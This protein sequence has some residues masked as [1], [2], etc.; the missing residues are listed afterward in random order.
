[1]TTQNERSVRTLPLELNKK[2][3][4]VFRVRCDKCSQ[5]F[6]FRIDFHFYLEP[7]WLIKSIPVKNLCER[8]KIISNMKNDIKNIRKKIGGDKEVFDKS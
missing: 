6:T 4:Y 8:C 3:F 2:H 7:E 5:I 1:M